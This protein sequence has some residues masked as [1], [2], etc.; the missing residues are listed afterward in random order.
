MVRSIPLLLHRLWPELRH[1]AFCCYPLRERQ[2]VMLTAR[3]GQLVFRA[4]RAGFQFWQ[5]DHQYSL[6]AAAGLAMFFSIVSPL[7]L[8]GAPCR[9]LLRPFDSVKSERVLSNLLVMSGWK[10]YMSLHRVL[11]EWR[12][13]R[14]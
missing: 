8:A 9:N 12:G 11:A 7:M 5:A 14:I 1:L 6:E 10:A 4:R 13:S 3:Y 2:C